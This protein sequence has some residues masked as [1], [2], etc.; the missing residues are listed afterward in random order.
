MAE[1]RTTNPSG[2]PVAGDER[3]L[4]VHPNGP[5]ALQDAYVVQQMQ[6]FD[7]ARVPSGPFTPRAASRTAS[8]R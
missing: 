6:L 1:Q 7:P 2:A 4:T 5:P 8:S 3:S